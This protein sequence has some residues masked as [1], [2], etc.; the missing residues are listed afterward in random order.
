MIE[1]EN[2]YEHK[3]P[4]STFSERL[5]KFA[6]ANGLTYSD[7][8]EIF[9]K[10]RGLSRTSIYRLANNQ[11][12]DRFYEKRLP[13]MVAPLEG[14][15]V[16][17]GW[18]AERIDTELN[19]LF[20]FREEKKVI[21][22]RCELPSRAVRFFGLEADPFD[23]DRVPGDDEMFSTPDLD[24][25]ADRIRDAVLYKRFVCVIGAVG[26]GKTSLKIRVARDLMRNPKVH[27][28]YPEFFDMNLVSVRAVAKSIL[29]EWDVK[30]PND[31]TTAVRRLRTLLTSLD[32]DDHRVALVF[33]E[34]HRLNDRVLTSLKNFW[35]MTNGGFSRLLGV[36]LFGQPR[37]VESTLRDTRF[38][39]IAE[40]IQVIEMPALESGKRSTAGEYLA[41][42]IAG[43]G[44]DIDE[45][46]DRDVVKRICAIAR[47]PLAL[48]NLANHCL[49]EAYKLEES[50][51]TESMLALPDAPRVRDMR[52]AA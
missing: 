43:A 25:T 26:T 5:D 46:F 27:L 35:E 12:D 3:L 18:S 51:V 50:R 1:L 8:A 44:G 42:R 34:C 29:D 31:S 11:A 15:C 39:E 52:R 10:V 45:L 33:D 36:V 6:L 17:R 4:K 23:V 16:A 30:C 40:R 41:H 9:S 47:T 20:P 37:F 22:D 2:D 32:R 38:R 7:L 19:Q 21:I 48:G 28:I 49:L 14:W 24:E 13:L